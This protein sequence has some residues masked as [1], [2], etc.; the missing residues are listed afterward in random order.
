MIIKNNLHKYFQVNR[1]LDVSLLKSC[2]FICDVFQK[3]KQVYLYFLY[4][5]LGSQSETKSNNDLN[6]IK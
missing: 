6:T 3:D 1:T 2:F 5:C 4:E